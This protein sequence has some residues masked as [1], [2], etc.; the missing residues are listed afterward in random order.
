MSAPGRHAGK[1]KA[2]APKSRAAKQSAAARNATRAI[3]SKH[4]APKA[5]TFAAPAAAAAT[6]GVVGF[7][8]FTSPF[9]PAAPQVSMDLVPLAAGQSQGALMAERDALVSRGYSRNPAPLTQTALRTNQ[10]KTLGSIRTTADREATQRAIAQADTKL[11]TTD[12]LNVY[13]E[14]TPGAR[15]VGEL[16]AGSKVLVTGRVE[17]E[18]AEI[19]VQGKARW[20]SAE[21]LSESEP[22]PGLGGNCS[23]GTSVAGG[24][25][26]NVVRVHQAVCAAFPEIQ[27]YGTL[28]GGGGDHPRGRAVD[29]MVSGARGQQVADFVRA[30]Y[31]E[32]GVSYV[33]YAQRIWSVERAGEGWRGMSNRGSATANHFDHVHVSTY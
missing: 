10:S 29:I 19:V 21:Y 18:R 28:R 11:W 8:V 31:A 27:V 24:V 16:K 25:S 30:H 4:R 23:N 26:S 7:G 6:V 12:E 20:V 15:K 3:T 13:D 9:G 5:A 2:M 17:A 33:I 22:L 1:R 32:L 14:P